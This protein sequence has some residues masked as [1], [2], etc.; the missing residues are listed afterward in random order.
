VLREPAQR[1]VDVDPDGVRRLRELDE[2]RVA[3]AERRVDHEVRRDRGGAADAVSPSRSRDAAPRERLGYG[4]RSLGD[5][6][7]PDRR[8]RAQQAE[9]DVVSDGDQPLDHEAGAREHLIGRHERVAEPEHPVEVGG[10][11][12]GRQR[13][14]EPLGGPPELAHEVLHRVAVASSPRRHRSAE[15]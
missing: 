3:V 6:L 10:E 14:V 7:R 2:D 5:V 11:A 15:P 12:L 8:Q 13:P 9:A 1:A 4:G